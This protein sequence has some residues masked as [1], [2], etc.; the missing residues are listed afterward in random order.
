MGAQKTLCSLQGIMAHGA[1]PLAPPSLPPPD[2]VLH[3]QL[4]LCH[5]E[6]F[7][8]EASMQFLFFLEEITVNSRV[9]MRRDI[10]YL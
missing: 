6:G 3:Q 2:T 5:S 1:D 7:R 9:G 8:A 10:F 4:S